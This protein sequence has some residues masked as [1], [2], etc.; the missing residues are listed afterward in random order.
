MTPCSRLYGYLGCTLAAAT[1]RVGL[2]KHAYSDWVETYSGAEYLVSLCRAAAIA[3]VHAMSV[4]QCGFT[5]VVLVFSAVRAIAYCIMPNM[6]TAIGWR[7]PLGQ[8]TWWG[9][10]THVV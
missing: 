2:S 7:L 9:C 10:G 8:S 4:A 6:P 1:E 3:M 5:C